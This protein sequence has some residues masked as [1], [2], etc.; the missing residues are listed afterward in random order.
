[1][2]NI[3]IHYDKVQQK[4]GIEHDWTENIKSSGA[5]LGSVLV[6]KFVGMKGHQLMLQTVLGLTLQHFGRQ[7]TASKMPTQHL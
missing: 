6:A 7:F 4:N 2:W 3:L 1:M 5:N